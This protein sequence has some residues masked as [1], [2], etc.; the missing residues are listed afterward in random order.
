MHRESTLR[1]HRYPDQM[2]PRVTSP[3]MSFACRQFGQCSLVVCEGEIAPPGPVDR[4][5]GIDVP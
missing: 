5:A 1:R 2:I 3:E 4:G